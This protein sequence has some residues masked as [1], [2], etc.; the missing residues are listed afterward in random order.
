MYD[1]LIVGAGLFGA[2]AANLLAGRGYRVAVIEKRDSPAGNCADEIQNGNILVSKHG[3]HIFHTNS[4]RIWEW[5]NKYAPFEAYTHRVAS[6]IGD[7]LYSFPVNLLTLNQL[8]GI[9]T[10]QEA[11]AALA[12]PEIRRDLE[13]KFYVG[14]SEK[15]WGK[16]FAELPPGVLARVPMRETCD[17]RYFTD[18][19]QGLPVG[20][21]SAWIKNMLDGIPVAYCDDFT[22]SKNYWLKRVSKVVYTGAIDALFGFDE[23]RLEYRSL[24]FENETVFGDYQGAATVNYPEAGVPYTRVMEWKHFGH[25]ANDVTVVTRE[26]PQAYDGVN[27]AYYPVR[28]AA[29]L[30]LHERYAARARAQGW[31]VGGR[32]GAYQYY[33]MDQAIGAAMALVERMVGNG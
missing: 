21:Y 2:T 9:T 28:D 13:A 16:P 30:A 15:Q 8:Y 29:S 23:G 25:R 10:P 32:L 11:R 14:Y 7:T 31:E 12:T 18:T 33:N 6:R 27:E 26:Y 4:A 5:A 19:Y 3:G 1:F 22:R 20:G 17:D 24:R